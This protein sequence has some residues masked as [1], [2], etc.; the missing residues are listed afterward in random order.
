MKRLVPRKLYGIKGNSNEAQFTIFKSDLFSNGVAVAVD[1]DGDVT[2][3]ITVS[4]ATTTGLLV[5]GAAT[6]GISITSV[7]GDAIHISGSNTTSAL[8]ISGDQATAVLVDVDAALAAGLSFAVDAGITMTAGILMACT[9]TGTITTAISISYSNSATEVFAVTVAT[10]K[11]VT[12]GMSFSGAGTY[13]TGIL[14]DATAIG[15]AIS[16]TGVCSAAC[17]D[18]G[19]ASVTTGSLIDYVAIVGKVSGYL[20]NGSLTTSTLTGDT[21]VDDFSCSC[22]HDGATADTLRM[23]RRIWTGTMTNGT[24]AAGFKLAEFC[25]NGTYGNGG[26]LGGDPTLL[27]LSSTT[28]LND[29]GADFRALHIDISGMTLSSAAEVYGIDVVGM[30]GVDAGVNVSGN[31]TSGFKLLSGTVTNFLEIA[32]AVS[33]TNFVKF[34]AL[35]GCLTT[36]DADPEEVPSGGGLGATGTLQ[37]DIGGT[38]YYIPFFDSIVS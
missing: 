4:G 16:I 9:T 7:C 20:F 14:F 10:A 6:D 24:A 26:S 13:T 23:I 31:V 38:P 8:H 1:H 25:W 3:A 32:A 36:A 17:I 28:V 30:T 2:T 34:D 18:F 35:S 21:L 27:T 11:T 19:P 29:S 12:T 15:T 33:V 5:S 37:I 22:A